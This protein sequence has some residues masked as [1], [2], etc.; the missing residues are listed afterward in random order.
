MKKIVALLMAAVLMLAVLTACSPKGSDSL[1]A[2]GEV[3]A[4]GDAS[5]G[6]AMYYATGGNAG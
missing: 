2:S 1:Y 4:S 6:N 3:F 5:S